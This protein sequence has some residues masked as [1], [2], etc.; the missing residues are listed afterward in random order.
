MLRCDDNFSRAIFTIVGLFI[1]SLLAVNLLLAGCSGNETV[2]EELNIDFMTN[3]YKERHASFSGPQHFSEEQI[4]EYESYHPSVK[5][6]IELYSEEGLEEALLFLYERLAHSDDAVEIL[7]LHGALLLRG[8]FLPELLVRDPETTIQLFQER[9]TENDEESAV[10]AY[11]TALAYMSGYFY[12]AVLT[13]EEYTALQGSLSQERREEIEAEATTRQNAIHEMGISDLKEII[14]TYPQ[15]RISLLAR[16]DYVFDMLTRF[17]DIE[18]DI[19]QEA[20]DVALSRYPDSAFV[21]DS[22]ISLSTMHMQNGEYEEAK[23][24]IE[25]SLEYPDY[26]SCKPERTAHDAARNALDEI[27]ELMNK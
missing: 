23:E 10:A 11:L 4:A 1:I 15:T 19:A 21:T 8:S 16:R 22:Y 18:I 3:A 7:E 12:E 6:I 5:N 20:L 25:K 26:M 24:L 17:N 14:E 9:Q 2:N 13:D 27:N